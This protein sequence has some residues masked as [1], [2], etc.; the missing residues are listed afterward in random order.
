MRERICERH[1][2]MNKLNNA[3]QAI[4]DSRRGGEEDEHEHQDPRVGLR[5]R[6]K[7]MLRRRLRSLS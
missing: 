5:R 2:K 6:L 7:T 3:A 1:E 4:K